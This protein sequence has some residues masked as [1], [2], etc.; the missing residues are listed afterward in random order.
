MTKY[1]KLSIK[2]QSQSLKVVE[3]DLEANDGFYCDGYIFIN[4][5]L[6]DKEKYCVLAEE[7]GHYETSYGNI[8]DQNSINN[9]K[10]ELKARR[11]GYKHIVSLEGI[12]EAFEN[13]CL[14]EYEM[15]EYLGVTD[16]YFKECIEDYKRQYGLS[17]K[18]GKYYIVFEPRLGIYKNFEF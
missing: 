18:L 4:K 15:A 3:V 10:Q 1:E 14:N 5:S 13:N 2:A 16:E 11:W 7:L 12:I 9:V 6:N 8:L 17:C